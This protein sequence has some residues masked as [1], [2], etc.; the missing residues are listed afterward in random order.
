MFSF[1]VE[2]SDRSAQPVTA[3]G[4]LSLRVLPWSGAASGG[5]RAAEIEATGSRA[6][7]KDVLLNWLHYAVTITTPSGGPCWW[8]YVHEVALTI[9]GVEIVASL[10]TLRNRIAITYT[11]LEGA[12]ES[13]L[14]TPWAEDTTSQGEY[15]IF[16]HYESLGQASTSM[17][18]AYRDRL[19]LRDAYPR[20]ARSLGQGGDLKAVLRCRGW[21]ALMERRYY[22][23]TD[24][25]LEHMPSDTLVQP[26]G[27]GV[28][29]SNQ[30]GFGDSGIHDAWG[31]LGNM[32]AG[33]K[34]TVT[35]SASNNKTFTVLDATSEEVESYSN[36]SIYFQPSDDILDALAGMGMVKSE[37]WL[38]ISGSAANSRWH[39]IGQASADHLRTSASVSGAIVNEA[40]GPSISMYQAQKLSTVETAAYEAPYTSNVTI[41]H[42][43]QQVAQRFTL[44]APMKLDRVMVE[45]AKV[46]AP[47]GNLEVRILADSGGAIGA[48]LTSGSLAAA[49]L[50][51]DL[52]AVWVPVTEITLSA[53]N[54]WIVVRRS[55]ALDGQNYFL[56]GMTATAYGTCQ[57]WTGS[58][59]VP[60]A[61]GWFVKFRLWAVEDTGTIAEAILQATAQGV[62]VQ[63]GFLSGVNGF[64]TMDS[65]AVALDELNRLVSVGMS[66]GKR[67]LLDVSPDLQLQ[68]VAQPAADPATMLTMRTAGGKVALFDSAGSPWPPG[69]LPAG[70]WVELADI[71]SDLTAVGGLSPAFIEEATYDPQ[72]NSWDIS[73]EGE[74]SLADLLK[75]QAG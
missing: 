22:L 9:D 44:P 35:G 52:A 42:H 39:R 58:A 40:T 34:L 7:L 25:R 47:A 37:H 28:S 54:Y 17:A 19:L 49:A 67:A 71:D 48:L 73:F 20:L 31:R 68:I 13:A 1:G 30:I 4:D 69:I 75:V 16:E 11:S 60:H 12:L 70:M 46:G 50:T 33:M 27:W 23:R 56:L 29:A 51:A 8:G 61:P 63:G 24:G 6:A 66:D 41:Q 59:W 55:D 18:T 74:R 64:P 38:S 5:P 26:I 53:G 62:T 14:T 36:N 43:G 3:L 15:G 2:L 65:Q 45:A 21:V 10:D 32:A 57:M 72:A